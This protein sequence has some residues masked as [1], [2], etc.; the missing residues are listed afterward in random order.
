MLAKI[1]DGLALS[2]TASPTDDL[3]HDAFSTS[4]RCIPLIRRTDCSVLV[5]A[6]LSRTSSFGR[7]SVEN[8]LSQLTKFT[9]RDANRDYFGPEHLHSPMSYSPMLY[10][11]MYDAGHVDLS[12]VCQCH[13]LDLAAVAEPKL[14]RP[15][16]AGGR[17]NREEFAVRAVY[18]CHVGNVGQH[19]VHA[20]NALKR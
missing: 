12:S 5:Q 18:L 3:D 1:F 14:H 19:H 10:R 9:K 13:T 16:G 2:C 7:F 17:I 15:R 8:A 4:D 20:H 11:P 6:E